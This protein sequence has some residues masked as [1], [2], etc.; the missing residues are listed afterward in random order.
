MAAGP[1]SSE[2]DWEP[3]APTSSLAVDLRKGCCCS[4]EKVPLSLKQTGWGPAEGFVS[5]NPNK[6]KNGAHEKMLLRKRT[7]PVPRRNE[8]KGQTPEDA[9]YS[10]QDCSAS[11]QDGRRN[12]FH[13]T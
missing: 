2:S 4:K 1:Q 12:V 3:F 7:N 13:K 6:K 11:L 8:R 10:P 5:F 9:G